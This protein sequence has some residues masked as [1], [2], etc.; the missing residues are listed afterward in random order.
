[1]SHRIFSELSYPC[2]SLAPTSPRKV[3]I[4]RVQN[5]TGPD[6]PIRDLVTGISAQALTKA[7]AVPTVFKSI[8]SVKWQV[9]EKGQAE[10][11]FETAAIQTLQADLVIDGIAASLAVMMAATD[12][13]P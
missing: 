1:M 3:E 7:A 9:G 8:E 6:I 13:L 10:A 5:G 4:W 12:S 2:D 11:A